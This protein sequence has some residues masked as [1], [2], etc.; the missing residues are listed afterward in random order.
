MERICDGIGK[1]MNWYI[2]VDNP[3]KVCYYIRDRG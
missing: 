3:S 2:W 1:F